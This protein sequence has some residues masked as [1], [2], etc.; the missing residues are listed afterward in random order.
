[1]EGQL[2][3]GTT[4]PHPTTNNTSNL[5]TRLPSYHR[6]VRLNSTL[7]S[8]RT[9]VSKSKMGSC[10]ELNSY[11]EESDSGNVLNVGFIAEDSPFS[12]S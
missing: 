10:E 7:T 11:G 1:M 12:D 6:Q 4:S 8:I 5:R 3:P 2:V 9:D